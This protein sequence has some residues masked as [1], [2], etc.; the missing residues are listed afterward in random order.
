MNVF[1]RFFAF[2]LLA[3]GSA[4][5][6]Q[7]Y[8]V[9]IR[10]GRIVNGSGNPWFE[11]DVG[12]RGDRIAAIG[13]LSA[14]AAET[15][16]DASGLVVAPGFIDPHTHAMQGIFDVPAA[17]SALLQG[18]TTLTEGNDGSSPWPI[19]EHYG[20]IEELG[21]STNWAV[22]V[23]QGTIRS[24]VIG[25]EDRDAAAPELQRMKEMVAQAMGR[26]RARHLHRPVLRA[27]QFHFHRGSDRTFARGGGLQRHLHLAHAR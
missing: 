6:A 1:I 9:L 5:A 27:R 14:A 4:A 2:A 26:R 12:I 24:I 13:D 21:I 8:D 25:A 7:D 18:V 17:D 16:I 19:G 11:A 23:G 10:G 3:L 22:F 20:E 15:V